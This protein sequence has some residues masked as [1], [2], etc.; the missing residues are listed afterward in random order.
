MRFIISCL[1]KNIYFY[2]F[3]FIL[4]LQHIVNNTVTMPHEIN[5]DNNN[6]YCYFL[7]LFSLYNFI[8][9]AIRLHTALDAVWQI[10][11]SAS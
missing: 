4:F 3:D 10:Y 7:I 11:S 2:D 8:F 9:I 6:I 5:M 1:S